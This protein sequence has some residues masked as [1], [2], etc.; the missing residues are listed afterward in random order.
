MEEWEQKQTSELDKELSGSSSLA[1]FLK[2]NHGQFVDRKIDQE[3]IRLIKEKGA[4]KNELAKKAGMSAVYLYQVLGG[5]RIPSRDRMLCICI[6]LGCSLEETQEVLKKCR[7]APLYSK[8][9]RDAVIMFA[10]ENG[11]G[12]EKLNDELFQIEEETVY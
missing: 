2:K 7:Y 1:D 11:W 4:Q 5:R 9:R 3:L 12:V 6:G 8:N 10:L